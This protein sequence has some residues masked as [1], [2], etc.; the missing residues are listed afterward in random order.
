MRSQTAA[1]VVIGGVAGAILRWGLIESV[2]NGGDWPWATL[3][4]NVVGCLALGLLVGRFGSVLHSGLLVG[5]TTGF[6]GALTTFS[7][8]AVELAELLRSDHWTLFGVY[9]LISVLA[10]GLAFLA[11]RDTGRRLSPATAQP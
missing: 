8:F 10:G 6:C 9:L 11:G 4:A 7:S 3:V 5:A 1:A 2:D